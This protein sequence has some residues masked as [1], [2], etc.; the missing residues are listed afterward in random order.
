M[1]EVLAD[2]DF[3]IRDADE[4]QITVQLSTKYGVFIDLQHAEYVLS[5]FDS[6]S[7][8]VIYRVQSD[9]M[10]VRAPDK[11]M[12]LETVTGFVAYGN[13]ASDLFLVERLDLAL[14]L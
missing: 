10:A 11:D 13:R 7:G 8:E 14:L 1:S 3:A 2:Q 6:Q 12:L 4:V 9:Q 5:Q